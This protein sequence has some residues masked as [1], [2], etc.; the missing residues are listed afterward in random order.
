MTG[1]RGASAAAVQAIL[2]FV[3]PAACSSVSHP[4]G[5][6]VVRDSAG[7]RI[8]ESSAPMLP[9]EKRWSVGS[10]PLVE[11]GAN[12]A[13]SMQ[14]LN[15][16]EAAIRLGDGGIVVANSAPPALRW[17]DQ[18]G[19]FLL[20]A[21]RYGQ[22]P[23]EFDGGEGTIWIHSLWLLSG[24][25][26]ATWEHSRRRMQVFDPQGRYVRSV[27]I[28]L[29]P[30][31]HR[32]AYP[33]MAGRMAGRFVAFL[34]D[35]RTAEGALGSLRR[36]S[37]AFILY[38]SE[39]RFAKRI[40]R[41]PGF[42]RYIGE[43]PD[44]MGRKLRTVLSP[45]FAPSFAAWPQGDRFFYGD[46]ERGE[47]AVYDTTGTLRQLVRRQGPRRA[48]T[49]EMIEQFRKSRLATV[50]TDPARLRQFEE[51]FRAVPFPDTLPA[52][53]SFRVDRSGMLWVQEYQP[54]GAPSVT[55]SVFDPDGRWTTDVTVPGSWEILD[56]GR[57]YL[58]TRETNELDVERVRMYRL[59]RNPPTG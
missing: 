4:A 59:T 57:D 9:P 37:V 45:P 20:G 2:A 12:E 27:V 52:Y 14:I 35:E 19:A 44:R 40:D 17:Y 7:I 23:G 18:N 48:V 10:E 25:S 33:Q 42:T 16:V 32:L 53:R 21:G 28:D 22:G 1:R 51:Q 6:P 43:I 5:E 24:D 38:T 15:Q 34:L 55:W 26:I 41:L 54:R 11:I 13:D 8:I 56:I 3:V 50:G 47:V 30:G 46:T 36:D 49:P 58:L 29:P 31:M 39:G